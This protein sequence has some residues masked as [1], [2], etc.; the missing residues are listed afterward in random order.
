MSLSTRTAA[1]FLLKIT[2]CIEQ[3]KKIIGH[4]QNSLHHY[5]YI[6]TDPPIRYLIDY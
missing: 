5:K 6:R 4:R 3:K 2:E 1:H